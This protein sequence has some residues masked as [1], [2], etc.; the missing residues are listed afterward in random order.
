MTPVLQLL[1]GIAVAAVF[2]LPVLRSASALLRSS[3]AASRTDRDKASR[4]FRGGWESVSLAVIG[5]LIAADAVRQLA[6]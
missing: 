5:L 4:A 6:V 3:Y 2:G 1:L